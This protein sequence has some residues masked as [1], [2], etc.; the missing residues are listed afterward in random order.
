MCGDEQITLDLASEPKYIKDL[1]E[2]NVALNAWTFASEIDTFFTND[3]PV[4]CPITGYRVL[5]YNDVSLAVEVFAT[6]QVTVDGTDL[7]VKT[8]N[9]LRDK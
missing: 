9:A 5:F 7:V 6:G 3:I 8:D 2:W 4:K 1:N